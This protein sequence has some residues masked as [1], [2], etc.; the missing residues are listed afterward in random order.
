MHKGES[1]ARGFKERFDEG[2]TNGAQWYVLYG[3]MQ[4]FNYLRSNSFEI[5]VEM[6]CQKF[7]LANQL[8]KFWEEHKRPLLGFIEQTHIGIK[9][10]DR[11]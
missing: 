6:G 1:C 9:V 7:P 10:K 4:D 8:E 5:T 3:G 11:S 2:I